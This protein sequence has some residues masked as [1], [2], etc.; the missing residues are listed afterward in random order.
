M[1]KLAFVIAGIVAG[2]LAQADNLE[3]VD[4]MICAAA[5]VEICFEGD[6]CYTATAAELDVPRGRHFKLS[7]KI[8]STKRIWS[9]PFG[10]IW[11]KPRTM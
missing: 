3:G 4:K 7:K 6:M 1:K 8:P 5:Q 10:R 2:G 9:R 11:V